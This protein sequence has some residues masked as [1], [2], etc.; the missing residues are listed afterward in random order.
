MFNFQIN[1]RVRLIFLAI[2][3]IF[4][5]IIAKVFYIEVIQYDK[6][7]KLADSLWSR[8]LPITADRGNIYDRN[9]KIIATNITTT[10]LVFIPN[11]I[12]DKEAVARDISSIL[13]ADYEDI[14]AHA[15]K[16]TSIERV[17]PEGRQLSYE[18]AEAIDELDYDGVYLVKESK[19]HY[20]YGEVLSHVLGYVGI[21]NQGLSG[22]ELNY[23]DYLTGKD[24]AIKYF[25]DGKGHRLNL[26]EVYVAPQGGMNL[27]LT[28]DLDL[29]LTIEKE[30]DNVIDMYDPEDALIL[31]MNPKT[32]EILAMANRPAF[33]PNNYQDYSVETINRNLSIWKTYEPG[34]T[35]KIVTLAAALEEKEVN[36]FE[37]TFYD[38]GSIRVENARIKCWKSGG[39]GAQTYLNVVENSCNP[40]FVTL[41]QKLGTNRLYNYVTRFGFGQKTGIDLNGESTGILFSLD[42]MGPVETATT[43]FGQGISVTP[44]QQVR[45]VSAVVNGGELL[46]PYIVKT[47]SEPETDATI[48]EN[49]KEVI[50]QVI[51]KETSD[52]AKYALESVVANG[53]GRNAYIENYRV[54]GKTGTAQK[55]EN[56]VYLHGNYILSFI[57]FMPTD[58]PEIVVYVAVN[59]PKGVSQYG[60][61]VSAPIARNVLMSAI[62]LYDIEPDTEGMTK[63]YRWYE[64]SYIKLPD[65]RGMNTKDAAKLLKEFKIEYSGV[66]ETVLYMSPEPNYYVKKGGTVKLMLK[67]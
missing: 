65:V 34:S 48:I 58:N 43:A 24:G 17:H 15:S 19:R 9:G 38:S 12:V 6:L 37:D 31:A 21:D 16:K 54:G 45:A 36:L 39:H 35:F 67:D 7:S 62:E 42:R 32:G 25:S 66:G 28:I 27:T 57:S 49:K 46:K 8:N 50:S 51:S 20:P 52:M 40:G 56:G 33:D 47:V 18:I 10:S 2:M 23:D 3:L 1:T 59:N 61:T 64:N 44:I 5:L 26:E 29:Q 41:G 4:I 63:E 55:V 11:Q 60:G 30:L 13:G 53:S 14:L 22:L